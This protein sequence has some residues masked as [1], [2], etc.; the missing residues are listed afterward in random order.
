MQGWK[1]STCR[2]GAWRRLTVF[3][4]ASEKQ[5]FPPSAEVYVDSLWSHYAQQIGQ[6]RA[7]TAT[8]H[9]SHPLKPPVAWDHRLSLLVEAGTIKPT[10]SVRQLCYPSRRSWRS[11]NNR[12]QCRRI[13]MDGVFMPSSTTKFMCWSLI[14]SVKVLE[15]GPFGV[16]RSQEWS[17]L[18]KTEE[19]RVCPSATWAHSGKTAIYE[20]GSGFLQYTKSAGTLMLDFVASRIVWKKFLLFISQ[21]SLVIC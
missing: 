19:T 2:G 16:I 20:S 8:T 13:C 6:G 4:M 7:N 14:L 11:H 3:Q 21:Q 18:W 10:H 5:S 15:V 1:G 17:P 12:R 9:N